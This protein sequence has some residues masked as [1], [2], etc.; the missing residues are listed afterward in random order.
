MD[1]EK[2]KKLAGGAALAAAA[3]LW[4]T[5][6]FALGYALKEYPAFF[7]L[8]FR[9]L[10]G[11]ALL[12]AFYHDSVFSLRRRHVLW[13][14]AL[15][16]LLAAGFVLQAY[17]LKLSGSAVKAAVL[18]EGQSVFVPFL[19]FAFYK[20]RVNAYHVAAAIFCAAGAALVMLGGK[21]SFNAGDLLTAASGIF[22][23]AQILVFKKLSDL[24]GAEG[25]L[26]PA[27]IFVGILCGGL[28]LAFERGGYG[29]LRFDIFGLLP[30]LLLAA[31]GTAGAQAFQFA[32]Q[33]RASE[34][35]SAFMLSLSAVFG[36]A[37][38]A[39]LG[40]P[41]TA[42]MLIGSAL[43]VASAF[44]CGVLPEIVR[45]RGEREK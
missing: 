20:E 1:G 4:G 41:L 14:A 29:G 23:A 17:G 8:A 45:K 30:L 28:S 39:C 34:S 11:G 32:G 18:T 36:V 15:A 21:Y 31:F 42:R 38:G 44:V 37:A 26:P 25:V 3:A 10:F 35:G 27:F 16:L 7:V 9:F 33:K 12:L 6:Y 19:C 24:G 5:S 2:K 22:F 43:I 13:A 40:E